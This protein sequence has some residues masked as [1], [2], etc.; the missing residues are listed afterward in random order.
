MI[1]D[2]AGEILGDMFKAISTDA[3]SAIDSLG[4]PE[5]A[6]VLDVGTGAGNSAICLALR[7]H[8]V[9]TGEPA[10]DE[11]HY[12][13]QNWQER[14]A[15][16]GV[17]DKIQFQAFSA[18]NMPFDDK[19]FD[20]VFFFGV[21]HHIDDPLRQK[22]FAEAVRVTKPGGSVVF[23]EPSEKTLERARINDPTHP[24]PADPDIYATGQNVRRSK[25]DGS[26]M[27]IYSYRRAG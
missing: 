23:Y 18:D 17:R 20:A 9:I 7:G 3:L 1:V 12:A 10:T 14:A 6:T 25:R 24:D 13:S 21:L 27:T 22:A 5:D 26:M 2:D 16:V 11:T 19:A 8:R 15:Q 4:L